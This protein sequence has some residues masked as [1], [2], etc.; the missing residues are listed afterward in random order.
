MLETI[1]E[2]AIWCRDKGGSFL[3]TSW[4]YLI[5][6]GVIGA[7]F[8][9]LLYLDGSF[10]MKL[11]EG[12]SISAFAFMFMGW[13]FRFFAVSFLM[14]S[15]RCKHKGI[16]GAGTFNTLGILVSIIVCAHAIGIGLEALDDK[17]DKATAVQSTVTAQTDGFDTKLAAYERQREG[18]RS[19]L[20]ATKASN[21]AAIDNITSDGLNNDELADVYRADNAQADREARERIAAIDAAEIELLAQSATVSTD[22][23]ATVATSDKWSP[24]F[25]GLAQVGTW[26]KEPSDWSIYIAG[27][28]FII[29]WVIVA[30]SLV[31]FLPPQVYRM[32]LHDADNADAKRSEAAKKGWETR[33]AKEARL[34]KVVLPVTDDGY[35]QSNAVKAVKSTYST[36][37]IAESIFKMNWNEFPQKLSV[38]VRKGLVS[39]E[40]YDD[41]MDTERH[42]RP[43]R[44]NVD[45]IAPDE[46]EQLSNGLDQTEGD[47]DG[48]DAST[49][50]IS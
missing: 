11:A 13:A 35:W 36:K 37:G 28:A 8:G 47:N 49:R 17:R 4:L 20:A 41:I 9:V 16:S 48:S 10:S 42:K 21:Q 40:Q 6:C 19:D 5:L 29:F 50:A 31:I 23:A 14:A 38:A 7:A 2:F 39:Q 15:E 24:L 43:K 44:N 12:S 18:I 34:E 30:E 27:V 26:S 3:A 25:V 1:K 33:K 46:T 22:S 45:V 32:M